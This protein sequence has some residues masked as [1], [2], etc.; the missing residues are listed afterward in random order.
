MEENKKQPEAAPTQPTAEAPKEPP[1][2]LTQI[3][4]IIS[5]VTNAIQKILKSYIVIKTLVFIKKL[6]VLGWTKVFTIFALIFLGYGI[7]KTAPYWEKFWSTPYLATFEDVAS[8]YIELTPDDEV[9]TYNNDL[10]APQHVVILNKIV[11][12]IK[13]SKT[14]TSNPMVAFDLFV[15]TSNEEAAVEIKDREKQ[16]QDHVQRL[17]EE[18]SYDS[19]LSEEGKQ[20]WKN[21]IKRELNL[22]LTT[23]RI[24][25]VLFKTLIIK[26]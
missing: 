18:F 17:C 22:V 9:I 4:Q 2:W 8:S 19:L 3:K 7:Y 16:F 11:V 25:E 5:L 26:P 6:G 13:P 14:S 24:K 20:T 23:G 1:K 10:L 21:K 15:R 12:N